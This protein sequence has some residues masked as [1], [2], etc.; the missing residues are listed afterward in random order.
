[1]SDLKFASQRMNLFEV[2]QKQDP[3]E[4]QVDAYLS[5]ISDESLD[6]LSH[7]GAEAP[8]LLNKYCCTVEDA[9]IEQTNK[10]LRYENLLKMNGL[11]HLI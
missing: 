3:E 4:E 9:L 1:M 10:A 8:A 5:Q 2:V 7:F 11:E 6:V